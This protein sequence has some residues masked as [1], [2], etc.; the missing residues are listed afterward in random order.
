MRSQQRYGTS[1]AIVAGVA[2]LMVL[3]APAAAVTRIYI[4]DP[5]I[6]VTAINTLVMGAKY[7]ISSVNFDQS[8][9]S[10]GGTQ[11]VPGGPNFISAN[12]GNV[13]QLNNVTYRFALTN[14]PGQGIVFALTNPKN[15]TTSLAWGS[16]TPA[17]SPVPTVAS[18][19]LRAATA[20]GQTPGSALSPGQ[21]RMNAL[22]IEITSRL[23]NAQ[24]YQPLVTLSDLSF[25]ASNPADVALFGTLQ[26]GMSATP[27]TLLSNSTFP[28]AG[29]GFASQWL[30]AAG[31]FWSFGWSL[32]GKVNAT[33]G[34]SFAAGQAGDFGEQVKLTISGKQVDFIDPVP[35]PASWSLLLAGFGSMGAMLRRRRALAA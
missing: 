29:S 33:L 16:F 15:V 25:V 3:P 1:L 18:A 22:H 28:E 6:P 11:N 13:A 31:D 32:S 17:L 34:N 2:A 12:L 26:S 14:T 4:N 30:L 7:R 19:T 24:N 9:D 27:A 20:T 10:G 21:L 23:R 35:E 8:L 5:T